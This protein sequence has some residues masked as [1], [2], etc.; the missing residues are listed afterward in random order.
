MEIAVAPQFNSLEE[1]NSFQV[2][3]SYLDL[4]LHCYSHSTLENYEAFQKEYLVG[5]HDGAHGELA[6][7]VGVSGVLV[8]M[9]ADDGVAHAVDQVAGMDVDDDVDHH[10]HV[11]DRP[12]CADLIKPRYRWPWSGC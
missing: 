6:V 7:L 3:N 10:G 11:A 5:F 8:A 2:G 12:H 1:T 9:D 4:D